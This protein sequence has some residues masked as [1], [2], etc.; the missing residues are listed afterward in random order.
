MIDQ[1]IARL[2]SFMLPVQLDYVF[3]KHALYMVSP[4]NLGYTMYASHVIDFS[5]ILSVGLDYS[6]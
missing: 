1:I 4:S 6:L 5:S 2:L 3:P